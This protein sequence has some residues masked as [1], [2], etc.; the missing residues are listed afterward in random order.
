M[1][2]TIFVFPVSGGYFVNQIT[3]LCEYLIATN[4]KPDV[5]M[6][7]SGGNFVSYLGE[8]TEWNTNGILSS[9]EKIDSTIFIQKDDSGYTL[10]VMSSF[11]TALGLFKSSF[12]KH[13]TSESN[14]YMQDMIRS[15]AKG[16][17]SKTEIWT[18][19]FNKMRSKTHNFCN[20]NERESIFKNNTEYNEIVHCMPH[21]YMNGDADIIINVSRASAAIPLFVPNIDINDELY[22]DGGVFY[23]S[24]LPSFKGQL[25]EMIKNENIHIVYFSSCNLNKNIYKAPTGNVIDQSKLILSLMG[26]SISI[27]DRNSAVDLLYFLGK[28]IYFKEIIG[29]VNNLSLYYN[30]AKKQKSSVIEIYPVFNKCIDLVSF[31]SSDVKSLMNFGR[32]NYKIKL[33]YV[34]EGEMNEAE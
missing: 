9:I 11:Y 14:V 22:M 1:S 4:S 7:S 8:S 31:T 24:P 12:Y 21:T 33:W 20:K 34:K 23:A 2:K 16:I 29:D 17:Y 5:S 26:I 18:G 27:Q 3:Y 13:S 25:S 30:I 10:G 32:K 15:S 28:K 19:T 6:G